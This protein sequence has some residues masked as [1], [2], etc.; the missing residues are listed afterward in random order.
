MQRFIIRPGD[1]QRRENASAAILSLDPAK[2]WA[3]EI[4]MYRKNRSKDQNAF[5]HAVP[6][7]ILS[8]HTGYTVEDMKDYLLGEF[9]GWD[10]YTMFGQVK[11]RPH[12]RSSELDTLQF[13]RF[14][15]WIE[16]WAA[17]ELGLMIPRPG[18]YAL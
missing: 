11:K 16:S 8:D 13:T 17:S 18:E 14:L 2:A 12:K 7:K 5:L 15:E 9:T 4:K 10:E 3:V 1:T 6:L